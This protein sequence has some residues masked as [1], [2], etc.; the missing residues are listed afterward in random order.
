MVIRVNNP[1]N[2]VVKVNIGGQSVALTYDASV[3]GYMTDE[4]KASEFGVVY[5]FELYEN[6]TLIQTL[7]YSVNKYASSKQNSEN[8]NMARLAIALYNL[9]KS[10]E[11][12]ERG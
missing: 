6:D 9:G 2:A 1:E 12:L 7:Q 11:T 8:D 5:S 3:G 10:A 4:I